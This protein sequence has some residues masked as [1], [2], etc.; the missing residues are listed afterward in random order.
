MT[1]S[2]CLVVLAL[3]CGSAATSTPP[4]TPPSAAGLDPPIAAQRAYS[5]KSPNGDRSDPYY[6][7]RDD[8]RKSP[9]VIGYLNAENDYTKAM[10][11][12]VR[13]LEDQLLAE[14]KSH[15]KEDD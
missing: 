5:V 6:W 1:R 14:M 2:V 3:G 11:E 10:L 13:A 12:P 7:L 8:T 15:I 9:D 4:T